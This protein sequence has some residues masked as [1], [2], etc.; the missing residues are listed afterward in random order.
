MFSGYCSLI[1]HCS[2]QGDREF[3]NLQKVSRFIALH[4]FVQKETLL[5]LCL[6]Q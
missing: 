3:Q 5:L 4:L 1:L 6:V 2:Y